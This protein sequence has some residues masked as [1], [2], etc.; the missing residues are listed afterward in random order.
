MDPRFRGSDRKGA[1]FKGLAGSSAKALIIHEGGA[2]MDAECNEILKEFNEEQVAKLDAIIANH[3][4]KP[5]GLIP[6]LEGAQIALEY[7]PISVQK[8]IARGLNLP[9]SCV[10]GVVTF[11]SFLSTRPMG[12]NVIRMCKNVPCWLKNADGNIENVKKML[13][14]GS[15]ETTPDGRFSLELTNCIGAC[16]KAP[17]MMVNNDTHDSLTDEKTAEILETYK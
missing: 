6:V 1:F 14:I 5:G 16:D 8:R 11:Y 12:R 4:G 7:L 3:K 10:Y 15:G 13:G 17:A 9:F 2:V